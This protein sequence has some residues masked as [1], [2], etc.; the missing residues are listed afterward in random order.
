MQ[1]NQVACQSALNSF[2]TNNLCQN[3]AATTPDGG[4]SSPKAECQLYLSCLL[5]ANPQGYAAALQLYGDSSACWQSSETSTSCATACA[6]SFK[7]IAGLCECSGTSCSKCASA[8]PMSA[9]YMTDPDPNACLQVLGEVGLQE[10]GDQIGTLTFSADTDT[11]H[12]EIGT[13][14]RWACGGP[15]TAT[16]SGTSSPAGCPQTATLT[17]TPTTDGQIQLSAT[18]TTSCPGNP[19]DVCAGTATLIQ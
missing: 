6:A 1:N 5:A 8:P 3:V 12:V 11:S 18:V 14:V 10:L 9:N 7:D 19:P 13:Q 17:L 15:A 2:H 4:A 16:W